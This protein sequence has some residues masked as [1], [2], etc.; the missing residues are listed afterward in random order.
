MTTLIN[1][2]TGQVIEEIP[3]SADVPA[4]VARA[5]AAFEQWREATP[6]ER[7]RVLLRLADLVERDADELTR[8]EVEETG[9]P[10]AVFRDG[11]LPFAADNL[12]FFAGAARSLDGTGAGV[13]SAGYTS[14]LIRRPVGV[15]GSIAPWNFPFIM[16]V[17]KV[18]PA[19][20]AGNGVVIK[21][22]PRTPRT[23]LRLA[24]LMAEAGAPEGLLG[25][26]TGGGD[27]GQALVTDPGVDMVS[28]TGSTATGKAVM[29]GAV[30]GL[31]RVH[32]E[33]GGKAPALV[34]ADADLEAMAF[35]VTMGATYNTGQ[36][37]TAATRVYV[38]RSRYAEAVDALAAALEKV[39]PGDPWAE[40]TDIGPLISAEHRD[41]VHGFVARASGRVVRGGDPLDAPG[42]YYA[43]TLVADADQSSEIVQ[44]EVFG[45]VLVALPFDGEDEAV[46]LANDTPYGLASSVWSTDVARALRV[47]HRL[48]V[49]VTWVN[50][51]LPIASEAPHGGVKGSGFGKDMSQEAVGE[52]S[53]TR[54]L[55]IK[56]AAPAE[57]DSFRPA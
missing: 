35:G 21:P 24:E 53:V 52:Y 16:A 57:R 2:A 28:V 6:S 23:T 45:P 13:L 14:V 25:V 20:A 44:G 51:H 56:H 42:Y 15:V 41:R 48:D 27:V 7:A 12:R 29:R 50:D 36:D 4:K 39:R 11:E 34:F 22:A 9:K 10:A 33:L 3:D 43:P 30:D 38:E 26:V 31:K 46:R 40:G 5:R 55:M 1:P 47:S 18:G 8:L 54:H 37:C 17:W 49:G 19:I 32:L